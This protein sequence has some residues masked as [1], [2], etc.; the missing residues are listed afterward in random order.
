MLVLVLDARAA[1]GEPGQLDASPVLFTVMAAINAS[2]YDADL[3]SPNNVQLRH[4]IRREI[5]QRNVPSLPALKAFFAKHRKR[6]DTEELGQYISFALSADGPPGFAVKPRGSDVPPD[7]SALLELSPLLA[8]FYKEAGIE[9]LWKRSQS[10][11]DSYVS[12]YH[13]AVSEAVLQ[14]NVY[15]RQQTSGFRGRHFQ[16]FVELLAAPNQVQTRSYSNEYTVVVTPS[17]D[18][19]VF[20]IRHGYLHYLLDPLSLR[21]HEVLDRKKGLGD[22]AKR[23]PSLADS[24]KDDFGQL[25]TESLIKVVEA[26]LDKKPEAAQQALREGFILAPYFAEQ[27]PVYEKQEQAMVLYYPQMISA[28][29]LYKEEKR[30]ASVEFTRETAVRAVRV[31]PAAPPPLTGAAKT[32]DEAEQLYTARDI[33]KAKKQYLAV[34]EQ[35]DQKSLHATAYYGLARIA[36]LEKDPETADRLFRKSLEQ[37]PEP[38]V[39]A[40]DLVY[41]GKLSMAAGERENAAEFFQNALQV[42]G[43]SEKARDEAQ[44]GLQQTKQ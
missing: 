35:T 38:Q 24:F 8:A 36:A 17:P 43:A 29:D 16:I 33:E 32:L 31:A 41:L 30:L 21:Y 26:R 19:R 14:A 11:I 28:I 3:T 44:K 7:V 40:W 4:D 27:L 34:L 18:L 2:G 10:A 1:A 42:E 20:D 5:A 39:K 25:A 6:T 23:A 15:L 13:A 9:D 12:R 37:M 22:H